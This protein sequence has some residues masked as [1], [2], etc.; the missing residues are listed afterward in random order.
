V[1]DHYFYALFVF[2]FCGKISVGWTEER[3]VAARALVATN[4]IGIHFRHF[5]LAGAPD[6]R[7]VCQ[8]Y[9]S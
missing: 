4:D 3:Q 9:T 2:F 6:V 8:G 1:F 5:R 7:P